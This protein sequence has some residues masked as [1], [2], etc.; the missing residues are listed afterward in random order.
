M[1]DAIWEVVGGAD[2]GGIIVRVGQ[3]ISSPQTPDRLAT[4]ALVEQLDLVGER[5]HFKKLDGKGPDSG[6]AS[7]RLKDK[8][9]LER[10]SRSVRSDPVDK[11]P[12]AAVEDAEPAEPVTLAN[13]AADR[14]LRLAAAEKRETALKQNRSTMDDYRRGSRQPL[15]PAEQPVIATRPAAFEI[16]RPETE[17]G[18]KD[19][20]TCRPSRGGNSREFL[21][22]A[23]PGCTYRVNS[24]AEL[25]AYC[26]IACS[27]SCGGEHGPRC[28]RVPAPPGSTRADP[29]ALIRMSGAQLAE[30][31]L[32]VALWESALESQQDLSLPAPQSPLAPSHAGLSPWESMVARLGPQSVASPSKSQEDLDLEEA[33]RLS[34][35]C[36]SNVATPGPASHA[37]VRAGTSQE[38]L[39]LEEAIR[40]SMLESEPAAQVAEDSEEDDDD[41]L[42]PLVPIPPTSNPQD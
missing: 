37:T 11:S 9:L 34:Q 28:E 5:L 36:N 39:D 1:G 40:L 10:T 4:G 35:E 3:E 33:I 31:E 15:P 29:A 6:W 23:S 21:M 18:V 24:K 32:N 41:D 14:A 19:I 17:V 27:E 30:H 2:K 13:T 22:C 7:I 38:E 26:C 20:P 25:G 8:A 16:Q 12:A 42:P